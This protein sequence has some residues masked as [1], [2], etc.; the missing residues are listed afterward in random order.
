MS[1]RARVIAAVS[2]IAVV[3]AAV[4]IFVIR[5]TEANLVSQV[6][7][8]LADAVKQVRDTDVGGR[9]RPGPATP[10][11]PRS[12]D[13]LAALYVGVVDGDDVTTIVRP[14]LRREDVPLP[15]I[16]PSMA[17]ETGRAVTASSID[18][19][20]RWRIRADE[21]GVDVLVIGLPLDTVDDAID[22]LITLSV[23]G[24]G[25]IGVALLLVAVWVIRLGV[26]PVKRMTDVATAIAGGDLTHR[27]PDTR[28]HTEAGELGR[29]LNI[30]LGSIEASFADRQRA[31]DR[32]RQFV[33]DASHELRTPI[34]TIRGYAELFRSG[35]LHDDERLADAMRRTEA[36]AI[37]MGGLV[38]D[39]LELA[40]LDQGR[41]LER[42]PV[43]LSSIVRD[44]A[45]DGRATAPRRRFDVDADDQVWVDADEAKIRQVVANLV[46][47]ALVHT[48]ESTSI[49]LRTD[50]TDDGCLIEVSDDGPGMSP[51]V[52]A[53]AFERFYRADPSRSRH[54]GGSGLGL[55]IVDSV[56]RAHGGTTTIDSDLGTGTAVR[57]TLPGAS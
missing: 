46:A 6:D 40:R 9:H 51:E 39:L 53:H 31:Q 17:S 1:L 10:P 27:V 38:E 2:L 15:D 11:A 55:S 30:M 48:P 25:V 20:L 45:E 19:D 18:A 52:A 36:E 3:L 4:L 42:R 14:G 26:R 7:E 22:D 5:T 24:A 29:A 32:L 41:P 44:A 21:S 37:R 34:A 28:A 50:T 43:D 16:D 12:G 49:T 54:Q 8:Q 56:I 13:E 35:G 47:N 23:V 33:A 57:V